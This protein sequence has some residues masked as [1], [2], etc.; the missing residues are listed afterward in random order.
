[1][2]TSIKLSL[3]YLHTPFFVPRGSDGCNVFSLFQESAVDVPYRGYVH[4]TYLLTSAGLQ[5]H[6]AGTSL[7]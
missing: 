2:K 7:L 5:E 4:N 3:A 6:S 1:M